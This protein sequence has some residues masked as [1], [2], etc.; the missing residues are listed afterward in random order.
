MSTQTS[1]DDYVSGSF[2]LRYTRHA[3][4]REKQRRTNLDLADVRKLEYAVNDAATHTS[5][6]RTAFFLGQHI[7]I[8]DVRT[9]E[10]ITVIHQYKNNSVNSYIS[11][12]DSAVVIA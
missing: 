9:Q 5:F 4:L 12:I 3:Q 8:I 10:V 6:K 7:F 11:N 2:S 1:T